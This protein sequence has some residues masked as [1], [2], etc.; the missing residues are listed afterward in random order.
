ML[1]ILKILK[2]ASIFLLNV[3]SNYKIGDEGN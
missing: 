3:L 1:K 2:L